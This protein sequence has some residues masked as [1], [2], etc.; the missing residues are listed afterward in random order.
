MKKIWVWIAF[1]MTVLSVFA[2]TPTQ[3]DQNILDKFETKMSHQN[4]VTLNYV[5]KKMDLFQMKYAKNE[6]LSFLISEMK[7]ITNTYISLGISIPKTATLSINSIKTT[8]ISQ[9]GTNVNNSGTF[10]TDSNVIFK[11]SFED[12][13]WYKLLYRGNAAS[14]G[15]KFEDYT[16]D[17]SRST[18]QFKY[19]FSSLQYQSR[20]GQ[21][22]PWGYQ[23]ALPESNQY[24]VRWYQKFEEWFQFTCEQKGIWV[25]ARRDFNDYE[26]GWH[27][28]G[29]D[30]FD[31]R[32]QFMYNGWWDHMTNG[33]L[34]WDEKWNQARWEATLYCYH[35]N[36]YTGYGQKFTQNIGK[37]IY[38]ESW[39]WY[40]YQ[41]KVKGNDIGKDN[42]EIQL[43]INGELKMSY[44]NVAFRLTDKLNL[45]VLEMSGWTG[46]F[47]TASRDQKF[48]IDNVVLSKNFIPQDTLD[49]DGSKGYNFYTP[50]HGN[51]PLGPNTST[52][53]SWSENQDT[54][55]TETD[56]ST[57]TI[58]STQSGTTSSGWETTNTQSWVISN[59]DFKMKKVTF[60]KCNYP[61]IQIGKQF[62]AACN[63]GATKPFEWDVFANTVSSIDE[64]I[65]NK[66]TMWY[67]FQ[68]GRNKNVAHLLWVKKWPIQDISV[69][70]DN[71]FITGW[72][73]VKNIW[74]YWDAD[75][76]YGPCPDGYHIPTREDWNYA[77]EQT[78]NVQMSRWSE[79]QTG[80]IAKVLKLPKTGIRN[81]GTWVYEKNTSWL[82]ATSEKKTT[83]TFYTFQFWN[84]WWSSSGSDFSDYGSIGL[85][86]R[87]I[88]N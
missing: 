74:N 68:W 83:E 87:C 4:P 33:E 45:N 88:K 69:D 48:R 71:Q 64:L 3:K 79:K 22:T 54:N 30:K 34:Y 20:K 63:L 44:T 38:T 40:D 18:A 78:Q 49:R 42:G 84:V 14:I 85:P 47:C 8:V 46:G 65:N 36:Q 50:K 17:T 58:P 35:M 61:D 29:Y 15:Q 7:K 24:Y 21:N 28:T 57:D 75:N 53:S 11:T 39:K 81:P 19:W 70:T 5:L 86:I 31:C 56:T 10:L 82:Y 62:W 72:P 13:N 32:I 66:D 23:F 26:A 1:C 67:L 60:E 59:D 43:W 12:D 52:G 16:E 51:P 27:P 41:L 37:K 55:N 76:T 25:R 6:R 80:M 77:V 2:Y 73:W 9:T